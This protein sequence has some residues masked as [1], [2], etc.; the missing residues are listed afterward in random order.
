MRLLS[1]RRTSCHVITRTLLLF[2]LF[3]RL[4][5]LRF[6]KWLSTGI[7]SLPLFSFRNRC[8]VCEC[9]EP[10]L[11][12]PLTACFPLISPP[13]A[14]TIAPQKTSTSASTETKVGAATMLDGTLYASRSD[15]PGVEALSFSL[16]S[17]LLLLLLFL[18]LR[19][20]LWFMSLVLGVSR[21]PKTSSSCF[22]S[23][24]C[25]SGPRSL[26][27]IRRA[28]CCCSSVSSFSAAAFSFSFL[29]LLVWG[30]VL[31]VPRCFQREGCR[32]TTTPR[33]A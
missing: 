26:K 5:V 31:V 13:P 32:R 6:G 24:R 3:I 16:C 23:W 14:G 30:V 17:L 9:G 28:A 8:S 18:L 33:D 4:F 22:G 19:L 29:L 21:R 1:R 25:Q 12:P 20:L 15:T 11:P 7:L 10:R 2:F 27:H